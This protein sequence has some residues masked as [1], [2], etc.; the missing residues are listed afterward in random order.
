MSLFMAYACRENQQHPIPLDFGDNSNA[1][2]AYDRLT[3]GGT[4]IPSAHVLTEE[5]SN[6]GL[7]IERYSQDCP[8][9]EAPRL[10]ESER[11]SQRGSEVDLSGLPSL[12]QCQAPCDN[13]RRNAF[14]MARA[15]SEEAFNR[16]GGCERNTSCPSGMT[17]VCSQKYR[18][19]VCMGTELESSDGIPTGS[20]TMAACKQRCDR[21][22]GGRLPSNN[23]WL[24]GAAGTN[25]QSCLPSKPVRIGCRDSSCIARPDWNSSS[26]MSNTQFNQHL[27]NPRTSCVSRAGLKDMVG[28]L[29]QWVTEG[30]AASN[31]AQFNG[32]LWSQPY[33]T[34][35]YRTT[36]HGPGYTDYSIGCRC[37]ATPK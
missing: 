12:E 37:A 33:S 8:L 4:T 30:Q 23:E 29:G 32:G 9:N 31:R 19:R 7:E 18:T 15:M 10:S 27:K 26:Q 11:R 5:I 24:V 36:A 35:Y 16:A 2:D 21:Y 17:F 22:P 28:V 13:N 1:A 25:A 6:P 34:V 3:D 20:I 14:N